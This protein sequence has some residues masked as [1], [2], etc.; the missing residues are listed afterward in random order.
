MDTFIPPITTRTKLNML[1]TE[2]LQ[3]LIEHTGRSEHVVI[4]E[5]IK[6]MAHMKLDKTDVSRM[7]ADHGTR[8]REHH[9]RYAI[10]KSGF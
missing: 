10:N 7:Y 6:M 3:A 5:A 1:E 2:M 4:K 8:Q 9:I